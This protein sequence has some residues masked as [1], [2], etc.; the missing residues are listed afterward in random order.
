[1]LVEMEGNLRVVEVGPRYLREM[2][3]DGGGRLQVRAR[4]DREGVTFGH[5]LVIY[6]KLS[7]SFLM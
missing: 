6:Y 3:V 5:L 1:M 7:V 2:F 4:T